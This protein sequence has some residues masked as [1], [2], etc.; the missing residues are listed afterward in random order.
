MLHWED[1]V[2]FASHGNPE[3]DRR[4]RKSDEEWRAQLTPEQYRVAR[5]KDTERPFTSELCGLFEPGVYACVCCG[6]ELF[7]SSEKFESRSGWPSFT[8][9]IKESAVAYHVDESHGMRRIETTCNTCEAHLGH[10]FPDGPK[11]S[12]LRYCINGVVLEKVKNPGEKATFGGGCFWC[13]EAVFKGVEGVL[14]IES[15]YSGGS[16]PNPTYQQVCSGMTGHAE[17]IQITFDPEIVSYEDLVR[18]HLASHD[19]T[20]LNRQGADVGTQYRS[21]IFT[22]D[23][24][25]ERIAKQVIADMQPLFDSPIVTEVQPF[26]EFFRAEDY[27]QDYYAKNPN[28]RYCQVVIEPKLRKLREQLSRVSRQTQD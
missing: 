28:A 19:P 22:H 24:E 3:P 20:T 4:V 26:T 1:V 13:T 16:V 2:H 12:G 11:P 17:A 10:V 23:A 25:Q 8:Q 9:P 6:A 7:D 14:S 18:L 5:N 15:G 21:A 27:H